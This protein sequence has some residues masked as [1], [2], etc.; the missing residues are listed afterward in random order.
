MSTK[1]SR[2]GGET[3]ASDEYYERLMKNFDNLQRM[4]DDTRDGIDKMKRDYE[5]WKQR[6]QPIGNEVVCDVLATL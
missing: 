2:K 6:R 4:I 5:E 1:K 3:M